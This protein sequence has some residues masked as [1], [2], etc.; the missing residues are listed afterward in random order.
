MAFAL[1]TYRVSFI[2]PILS[3]SSFGSG[4]D[5]SWSAGLNMAWL[6]TSRGWTTRLRTTKAELQ[7]LTDK[8]GQEIAAWKLEKSHLRQSDAGQHRML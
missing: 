7:L 2:S 5:E 8:V 3:A 1:K 4:V 6:S